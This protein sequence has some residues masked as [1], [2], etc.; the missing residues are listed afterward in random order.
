MNKR[1]EKVKNNPILKEFNKEYKRMYEQLESENS[2]KNVSKSQE[3]TFI[4]TEKNGVK[5]G[6]LTNIGASTIGKRKM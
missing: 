5:K 3:K 6:Y 2:I 4:L 1:K